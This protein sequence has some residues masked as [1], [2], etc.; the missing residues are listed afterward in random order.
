[1]CCWLYLVWDKYQSQFWVYKSKHIYYSSSLPF[2]IVALIYIFFCTATPPSSTPPTMPNRDDIT[3]GSG[4][5]SGIVILVFVVGKE[6]WSNLCIA[7]KSAT[8]ILQ[9]NQFF[10]N[11]CGDSRCSDHIYVWRKHHPSEYWCECYVWGMNY[12]PHPKYN[13]HGK[14]TCKCLLV[15]PAD[16]YPN[17]MEK[18]FA[19]CHK[20]S[21]FAKSSAMAHYMLEP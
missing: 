17:F 20:T 19:N 11:L 8:M 13:F 4:C 6:K 21:K 9:H 2:V 14:N 15:L 1:M 5:I 10:S 18:T 16:T 12:Y 3:C 7:W